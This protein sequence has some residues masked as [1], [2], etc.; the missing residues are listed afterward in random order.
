M[1]KELS[2]EKYDLIHAETFYV[3]PHI[4]PT[5]IPVLL[6]EQTIEYQVYAHFV[7][8]LPSF[9]FFLKPFLYFDVAKLKWWEKYYWKKADRVVA[10]S[11]SDKGKM[12]SL[13]KDLSVGVVPNGAG[14]DLMNVW[15]KR[16]PLKIPTVFFQANFS[17]LQN[18]EA[19]ENLVKKIFPLIREE[20]PQVK[21]WIVGQGAQK[22]VGHLAGKG[23]KVIDLKTSDIKGVIDVYRQAT[24]F[25]APLQGPGGTRLKI[26][27]AMAAGV[28]VV[29]TKVGIEGIRARNGQEALVS[30]DWEEMA[31]M[32]VRLMKEKELYHRVA[33]AARKLIESNYSYKSVARRLDDIYCELIYAKKN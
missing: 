10:V 27:A 7:T 2:R 17:W 11:E 22:K 21:C 32:A 6:V 15:Q 18:T 24:V 33:Q 9:L 30:N 5:K 8:S 19:A 16:K 4:P 13:V 3:M 20:M 12:T 29:A 26:L 23:V 31:Q 25:M 14:E 1:I 28:P